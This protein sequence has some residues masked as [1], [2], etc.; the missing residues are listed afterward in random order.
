[1]NRLLLVQRRGV[2]VGFEHFGDL[3]FSS[4]GFW[5][6]S[7]VFSQTLVVVVVV[8]GSEESASPGPGRR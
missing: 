1:M 6:A 3:P 2:Y 7:A 4:C 8:E 5:V